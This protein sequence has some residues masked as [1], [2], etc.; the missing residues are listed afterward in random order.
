MWLYY[1][2]KYI[3]ITLCH[4]IFICYI[5]FIIHSWSFPGIKEFRTRSSQKRTTT[6]KPTPGWSNHQETSPPRDPIL[7]S[8]KSQSQS[9]EDE[10]GL[11][12]PQRETLAISWALQPNTWRMGNGRPRGARP[13]GCPELGPG[14][15]PSPPPAQRLGAGNSK[16]SL[17]RKSDDST[18]LRDGEL[19]QILPRKKVL[20]AICKT[21]RSNSGVC[22]PAVIGN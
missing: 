9:L 19:G 7:G 4:F 14:A 11:C 10:L 1:Y 3:K 15:V 5:I 8:T 18:V 20:V 13:R 22:A 6:N 17:R 2:Y 21:E 12:F 16:W